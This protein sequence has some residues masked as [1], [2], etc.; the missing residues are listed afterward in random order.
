MGSVVVLH[1]GFQ[2]WN[3]KNI[4]SFGKTG[5]ISEVFHRYMASNTSYRS[6]SILIHSILIWINN[7]KKK[8]K[9][10]NTPSPQ[11]NGGLL[12]VM[13]IDCYVALKD[14]LV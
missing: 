1:F 13:A 3:E 6:H 9:K 12:Y 2:P 5:T 14:F 8:L 10:N 7:L 11:K 4:M